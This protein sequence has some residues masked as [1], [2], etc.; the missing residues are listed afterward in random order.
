MMTASWM[1]P[2]RRP[3]LGRVSRA[4]GEGGGRDAP[5][6]DE[7]DEDLADDDTHDLEIGDG[8]DPLHVAG[9]EG[10]PACGPDGREEGAQVADGEEDVAGGR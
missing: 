7:A 4:L 9:L 3:M 8:V 5:I 1:R 10:A 6:T 2:Q